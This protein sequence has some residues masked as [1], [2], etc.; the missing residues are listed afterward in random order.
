M[1]KLER[2]NAEK[3]RAELTKLA[4]VKTSQALSDESIKVEL[5]KTKSMPLV[6]WKEKVT[7]LSS[8]VDKNQVETIQ[9]FDIVT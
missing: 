6:S 2:I 8:Q 1:K 4:P 7:Y 3:L 5:L 9:T